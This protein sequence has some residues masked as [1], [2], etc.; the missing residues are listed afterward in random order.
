ML[1]VVVIGVGSEEDVRLPDLDQLGI[2]EAGWLAL[3]GAFDLIRALL[4][5][6]TV[7]VL[8]LVSR[9]PLGRWVD[10]REIILVGVLETRFIDWL[11][12]LLVEFVHGF[13][14]VVRIFVSEFIVMCYKILN[15]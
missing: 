10:Y 3:V 8:R 6:M 5:A 15:F 13:A 1:G 2:P 4:I 14:L 9:V 11:S 12:L 7:L